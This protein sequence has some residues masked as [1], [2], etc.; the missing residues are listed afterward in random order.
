MAAE[1]HFD[2]VVVGSGF[3]GA[4]TAYRLGEAKSSVL[5]LE[6][7]QPYPPGSFARTPRQFHSAFWDPAAG[8][9]GLYA[10]W[11]F[12]GLKAVC[13]SGLGGGSL[14]YDNVMIR[15]D[16]DTFVKEDL[17]RGG[18]ERWP[19]SYEDLAEHYHRVEE[20]QK[21]APYPDTEPYASTPKTLAMHDAAAALGA[22]FDLPKLAIRFS[23]TEG[24]PPVPGAPIENS[25]DLYGMQRYTCRLCG[26]C[27]IGCNI[28]AKNTLDYTYLSAAFR[29]HALIRTCCEVRTIEPLERGFR[30]GYR[31]HLEA[32]AGHPG[33]L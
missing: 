31:Q 28:G 11:N 24:G 20:M 3:G 22:P 18:R 1:E 8:L 26:E 25:D 2:V 23:G 9:R 5:V 14:I 16:P 27:C 10:V 19:I 15:K 32:K 7:G 17:D 4:V 12:G 30:V 13:S 6:R 21:P 29:E 33:H